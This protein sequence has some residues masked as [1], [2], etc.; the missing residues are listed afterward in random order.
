MFTPFQ[1]F[2]SRRDGE[3]EKKNKRAE[4]REKERI[5]EER[6]EGK[7]NGNKKCQASDFLNFN[8][9]KKCITFVYFF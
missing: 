7:K 9:D 4:R 5:K 1:L 8:T 2:T 3:K 6:T